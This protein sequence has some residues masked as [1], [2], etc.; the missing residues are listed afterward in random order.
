MRHTHMKH[1]CGISKESLK[2]YVN[3]PLSVYVLES[4]PNGPEISTIYHMYLTRA[5][6]WRHHAPARAPPPC[7]RSQMS[8]HIS[9]VP[10]VDLTHTPSP[11][12]NS[13]PPTPVPLPPSSCN[14]TARRARRYRHQ[15]SSS[16][17]SLSESHLWGRPMPSPLKPD[18]HPHP[19][20]P[21]HMVRGEEDGN[22]SPAALLTC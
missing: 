22:G 2:V 11:F 14:A 21:L 6:T 17:D 19:H 4:S 9:T 5:S 18:R 13:R 1:P 15:G 20:K 16:R 7:T 12:P 3:N 10:A 8:P